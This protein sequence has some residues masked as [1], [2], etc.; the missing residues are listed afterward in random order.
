ML[1]LSLHL[2]I[3]EAIRRMVIHHT[4]SLHESIADGG[5]DELEAFF[6]EGFTHPVGKFRFGGDFCGGR[7]GVL[8]GLAV[9]KRPDVVQERTVFFL[10][11][12]KDLRVG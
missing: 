9:N 11:F 12:E 6:L 3:A 4:Y 1:L 10:H 5:A 2:L 7:P 8:D